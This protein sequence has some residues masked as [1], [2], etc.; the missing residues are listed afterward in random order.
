MKLGYRDRIILL[1]VLVIAILGVGIFALIKPQYTKL[2]KNKEILEN[3][4]KAW[5]EQLIKFDNIMP[6]RQTIIDNREE[7][8][9]IAKR[10]TDEMSSTE[11]DEL[12]QKNFTNTE[13]FV[14]DQVQLHGTMEVSDPGTDSLAYY[15]YT[16][17]V[18]TYP[19]YEYA[20]LDGSLK[21]E[22]AK[23]LLESTYLAQKG[24]QTV[25][26]AHSTFTLYCKKENVMELVDSVRKYATEHDDAMIINSVNIS[27]YRFNGELS[28]DATK[29]NNTPAN[30]ADETGDGTATP[31]AN[32]KN[33]N[34][35]NGYSEVTF[36]Y[37]VYYIQ[38][39]TGVGEG[40]NGIGP[41]YKKEVWDGNEWKS[42][43]IYSAS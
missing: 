40:A 34:E 5:N 10:F 23:K 41:E 25:G 26:S 29:K 12:I 6:M 43:S 16:P 38:A 20:D 36:N 32:N 18:I 35:N 42:M 13:K 14:Q 4:K 22:T 8:A 21:V 3:T 7:G 24:T 31:A 11:L 28:E 2:Q 15:Y 33:A 37:T 9:K 1:I 27:E 39:P 17:S 19:L 30:T